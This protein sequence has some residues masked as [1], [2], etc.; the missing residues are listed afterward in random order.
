MDAWDEFLQKPYPSALVGLDGVIRRLNASMATALGKPVDHCVDCTFAD[1]LPEDQ[2]GPAE[3][4]IAQAAT[5]RRAA[6]SVL[7]FPGSE[8]SSMA[9]LVEARRAVDPGSDEQLVWVRSL[10]THKDLTDLLRFPFRVAARSAGLGI[11]SYSHP[12]HRLSWVGGA[13]ELSSLIGDSPVSLSQVI[14]RIHPDDR[15]ALRRLAGRSA[16]SSRISVRLETEDDHWHHLICQ[17]RRV[18]LG[19]GGPKATF[20]LVRDETEHARHRDKMQ[21]DLATEKERAAFVADFAASLISVTT[22]DDLKKV[23][24]TRLAPT[25]GS[26]GALLGLISEDG[27]LHVYTDAGVT[28]AEADALHGLALDESSPLRHTINTGEQL[29]IEGGDELERWSRNA[30]LLDVSDLDS[31]ALVTSLGHAEGQPLGAWALVCDHDYRPSHDESAL[32]ITLADL[33]GQGLGRVRAQQARLELA[34]TVQESMLPRL[35]EEFPGLE[36]AARYRPSRSGLDVGGDWYDAYTLPDGAV[37]LVIGD[38]QGHD[39]EA[40]AWMGRLRAIIRA[41]ANQGPGPTAVLE[42]INKVLVWED[43]ARFAS[44]T[45]LRI[46]PDK[47]HVTGASAGHVPMVRAFKDGSHDIYTLPGGP[48][49]GVLPGSEFP[50]GTFPLDHDTALIL[51]TDGLVEG[52]GLTLEDG[53]EQVGKLAAGALHEGLDTEA[54]ADRILTAVDAVDHLDDVALLVIRRQ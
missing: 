9:I 36:I 50:V 13:P 32:M 31:M 54:I 49:L 22:E 47:R 2:Q 1:L 53:L 3:S 45:L 25:F 28:P 6:M 51:T 21:A 34:E 5:G 11:W 7:G 33:A 16:Q 8:D 23:I 26:I 27:T 48:V 10:D 42:R 20:V 17:T 46:H 24:M 41:L 43:S 15:R 18:R 38:V 39:V 52:P 37:A 19:Y 14:Q 44:C 29:L 35:A 12:D 40:A 4:L 30:S